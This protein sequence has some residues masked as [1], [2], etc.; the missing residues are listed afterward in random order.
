MEIKKNPQLDLRKDQLLLKILGYAFVFMVCN[1][2]FSFTIYDKE[3]FIP[4]ED[5]VEDEAKEVV[6]RHPVST[7]TPPLPKPIFIND[8]K[9]GLDVEFKSDHFIEV[10]DSIDNDFFNSNTDSIGD[11]FYSEKIDDLTI[12]DFNDVIDLPTFKGGVAQLN[13]FLETNLMYPKEPY[14]NEIEGVIMVYFVI[15]KDGTI[16][17]VEIG[18]GNKDLQREAKRI[19][20]KT[21]GKWNSGLIKGKPIRVRAKMPITFTIDE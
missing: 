13:D 3:K 5:K 17:D 11:R 16:S 19:I 9:K 4:N 15:N 20:M 6:I 7:P 18:E 21:N 2:V 1:I 12:Y 14:E 10:S 8:F